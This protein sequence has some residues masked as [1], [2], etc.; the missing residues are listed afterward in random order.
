MADQPIFMPGKASKEAQMY[1][2]ITES[3]TSC[4]TMASVNVV[5]LWRYDSSLLYLR[6]VRE[7][8]K[9]ERFFVLFPGICMA[10]NINGD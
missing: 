5:M 3:F 4:A 6:I 10:G 2:G 9:K 1:F 8:V 7:H